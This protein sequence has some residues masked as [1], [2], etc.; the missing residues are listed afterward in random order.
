MVYGDLGTSPLYVFGTTFANGVKHN[1]D[2]IAVLALTLYTIT[3][4]PVI[5][6]ACIVL[7]ANDN[8]DGTFASE[9]FFVCGYRTW[10]A[11]FFLLNLVLFFVGGTFALYSLLCRN[12][13]VGLIPNQEK[14]DRN[15]SNYRLKNSSQRAS[16]VKNRLENSNFAKYFLLFAT[17]LGTS[18]VIGDGILTPSI[19]VLSAVV[20]IKE[21]T[22]KITE[23]KRF[24]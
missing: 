10:K 4:L 9:P 12:V 22:P 8:G 2:I 18:M 7:R 3:L 14:E 13:K 21:A 1:D 24:W 19:S 16:K 5:K 6:Y 23:G 17:M 11:V 20:G 15:I